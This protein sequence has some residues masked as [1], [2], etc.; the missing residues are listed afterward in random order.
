MSSLYNFRQVLSFLRFNI[1]VHKILYVVGCCEN[2]IKWKDLYSGWY[3]IYFLSLNLLRQEGARI[4]ANFII[5]MY[6]LSCNDSPKCGSWASST[7]SAW[8]PVRKANSLALLGVYSIRH[9]GAGARPSALKFEN[10]N[11]GGNWLARWWLAKNHKAVCSGKTIRKQVAGRKVLFLGL[12][13][14]SMLV[15]RWR[16]AFFSYEPG[17]WNLETSWVSLLILL[18]T[19]CVCLMIPSVPSLE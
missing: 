1:L 17:W 13:H 11:G 9:S 19:P 15:E 3:L 18:F 7:H 4:N 5:T 2:K 12:M 6:M 16:K 8:E 14:T 10:L